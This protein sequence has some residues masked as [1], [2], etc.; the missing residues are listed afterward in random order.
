MLQTTMNHAQRDLTVRDAASATCS[1]RASRG[2]SVAAM[3]REISV[4]DLGVWSREINSTFI[5]L[6]VASPVS[7][8]F[9]ASLNHVD[10]G[11]GIG[12]TT[13]RT[14]PSR[15]GRPANLINADDRDDILVVTHVAGDCTVHRRDGSQDIRPG[16]VSV[17]FANRAY[18]LEFSSSARQV[19]F[20]LPRRMLTRQDRLAIE[21]RSI[22]PD[23][24]ALRVFAAC[25]RE[26][27]TVGAD[28][29]MET[30][31]QLGHTAVDLLAGAAKSA[32]SNAAGIATEPIA[33]LAL[34]DYVH[35][36]A[37]DPDLNATTLAERNGMSVR[38]LQK[39]F[40]E[41]GTSPALFIRSAR[42]AMAIRLLADNRSSTCAV[43]WAGYRCGFN[44]ASTF[45][46]AF[47]SQTGVTPGQ[48][49]QRHSRGGSPDST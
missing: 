13:I 5:P 41:H 32:H 4:K 17:H 15:V 43:E 37:M 49:R 38:Y 28:L 6:A 25:V 10:L 9:R 20:Q 1:P 2:R 16:N 11:G 27:A 8:T 31:A 22:T 30:R 14:T 18:E 7:R 21:R 24:P 23:A 29:S 26:L 36:H 35:A 42:I 33:Y 3:D 47:K 48:W 40:A 34:C 45:I 39:V 44:D 19:V 12:V 46:R